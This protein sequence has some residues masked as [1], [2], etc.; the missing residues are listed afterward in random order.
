[1]YLGTRT[2]LRS[3][4]KKS[5][6]KDAWFYLFDTKQISKTERRGIQAYITLNPVRRER[7]LNEKGT[8]GKMIFAAN[9]G[10]NVKGRRSKLCKQ[11]GLKNEQKGCCWLTDSEIL[12]TITDIKTVFPE[13]M[14]EKRR[15]YLK[16]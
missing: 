4:N 8:A 6:E 9:I 15:E 16:F 13:T 11:F 5:S 12:N 1:L 10:K 3:L 2:S 14:F 7:I